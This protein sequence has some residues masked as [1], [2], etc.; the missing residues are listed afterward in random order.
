MKKG[1]ALKLFIQE[2]STCIEEAKNYPELSACAEKLS[3]ALNLFMNTSESLFNLA[4]QGK[5]EEFLS[6]ATLYLEMAGTLA[7]AWQWLLQGITAVK[8]LSR[9]DEMFFK[10]FYTAKVHTMKYFFRYELPAVETLSKILTDREHLT[11][12]VSADIFID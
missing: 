1:S 6:D 10:N 4:S 9:T 5:I 2:I 11:T 3:D 12:G 8:G 7:I